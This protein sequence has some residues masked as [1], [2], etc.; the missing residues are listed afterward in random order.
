MRT[1]LLRLG[2]TIRGIIQGSAGNLSLHVS[3][4]RIP[5]PEGLPL[6]SGQVVQAE[7]MRGPEGL[8]LRI[9]P[10]LHGTRPFA[11]ST[12]SGHITA[13][14]RMTLEALGVALPAADKTAHLLPANL[15][16]TA[17]IV[18]SLL[19]LFANRGAMTEDLQR[20]MAFVQQAAASGAV[21]RALAEQL[22]ALA[23][24]LFATD[25][26]ELPEILRRAAAS[27][28]RTLE[29]RL[30][31]ALASGDKTAL[32]KLVEQDLRALLRRLERNDDLRKFL[33]QSRKL[34]DFDQAVER[35]TNRLAAR[36]LQ[37]LRAFELPYLFIELP[38]GP[39]A[40]VRHAQI[41]LFGED[42]PEGD[43]LSAKNATV[44]LDLST[45]NLG[46]L[47]ISITIMA[48]RC[49]CLL[50]ATQPA[51]VEA[52]RAA[53]DEL[54]GSLAEAGY[55]ES[56]IEADLWQGD[57]IEAVSDLMRRFAGLNETA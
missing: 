45:S 52:I 55:P 13:L 9:L 41:H 22:A 14:I 24:T 19:A 47:W 46:D 42:S 12:D 4:L 2:Q 5:L 26:K 51:T 6:L 21:P 17:H 56:I 16:Q 30:A 43:R 36:H 10:E 44:V 40:P 25:S 23:G 7:V 54:A 50:R 8:Q 53:S 35:L 28:R 57:R 34:R 31:R 33:Q 37:N 39:D 38:F 29:A 32:P 49:R 11:Q 18:Q 48:G 15:P 20:I 1:P 27:A 3:G